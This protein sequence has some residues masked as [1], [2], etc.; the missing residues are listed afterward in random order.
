M[1]SEYVPLFLGSLFFWYAECLIRAPSDV[2]GLIL[3]ASALLLIEV[4]G[5]VSNTY[6]GVGTT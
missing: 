2:L 5:L 3:V 6:S 4:A 1:C